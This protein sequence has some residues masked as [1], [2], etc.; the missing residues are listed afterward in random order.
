MRFQAWPPFRATIHPLRY[1]SAT[2]DP[3]NYQ[4]RYVKYARI[5][6][7]AQ[8][9]GNRAGCIKIGQAGNR[10]A[11]KIISDTRCRWTNLKRSNDT[12]DYPALGQFCIEY[13]LSSS[14]DDSTAI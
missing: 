11:N 1:M 14:F 2:D 4:Y 13:I 12:S 10:F 8:A 7:N 3:Q 9:C 6:S 5:S